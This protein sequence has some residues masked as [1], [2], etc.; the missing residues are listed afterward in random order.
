MITMILL[1]YENVACIMNVLE[2]MAPVTFLPHNLFD[3]G[4]HHP[5]GKL[6]DTL[7]PHKDEVVMFIFE[8]LVSIIAT[9]PGRT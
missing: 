6:S 3:H 9:R 2:I 4:L 7:R 8:I 1:P 5:S